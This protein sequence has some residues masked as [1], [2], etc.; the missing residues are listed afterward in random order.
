[1]FVLRRHPEQ[2]VYAVILSILFYVVILTLSVVEWGRIPV[3]VVALAFA[4]NLFLIPLLTVLQCMSLSAYLIYFEFQ[5][6]KRMSSPQT[7]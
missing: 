2:F 5:P 4:C 3:F 7:T 1:L 6:K